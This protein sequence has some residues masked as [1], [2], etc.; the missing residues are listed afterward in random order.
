MNL[1]HKI[2]S[3]V[4]TRNQLIRVHGKSDQG[5]KLVKKGVRSLR[6]IQFPGIEEAV[7]SVYLHGAEHGNPNVRRD[8]AVGIRRFRKRMQP[9]E[10]QLEFITGLTEADALI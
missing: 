8:L 5:Q 4:R 10:R 2:P 9:A 3:L 7:S 1:R 6:R